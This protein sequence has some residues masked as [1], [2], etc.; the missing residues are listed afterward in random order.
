MTI[1]KTISKSKTVY[2]FLLGAAALLIPLATLTA[3]SE[4]SA[5]L[6]IKL[7]EQDTQAPLAAEVGLVLQTKRGVF[8]KHAKANEQGEVVFNDLPA[9]AAHLSTKL[10]GYAVERA[11]LTLNEGAA[12]RLILALPRA[13]QI[14]GQVVDE[15]GAPLAEASV[16]VVYETE[17]APLSNSYQWETGD[18]RTDDAGQFELVVH[19]A[20]PFIVVATHAGWLSSAS[21][22]VQANLAAPLRLRLSK[23][24][25][26]RGVAVNEAGQPLAHARVQLQEADEPAQAGRFVAFELLQQRQQFT[27]TDADGGFHFANVRPT[28]QR[29]SVTH[30]DFVPAQQLLEVSRAANSTFETR[31]SLR[32]R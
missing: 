6:T 7:A 24:V 27:V 21:A 14:G 31:L 29:L 13:V 11:G 3:Q 4:G 9:G 25:N 5:S 32:A 22:P 17:A 8:L 19:P 15:L 18:A 28:R 12:E 26:V 20:R 2:A 23:G 1:F 30:Q 10:E 16:K